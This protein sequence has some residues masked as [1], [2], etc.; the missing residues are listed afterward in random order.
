MGRVPNSTDDLE[1]AELALQRALLHGDVDALDQ[2]LDDELVSTLPG[3]RG[4]EG[5]AAVLEAHR[6]GILRVVRCD[7]EQQRVRVLTDL[8]LTFVTAG[9]AGSRGGVSFEARLRFTRNWRLSEAQ[10]GWQ[11]IAAH[12]SVVRTP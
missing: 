1:A 7:V 4:R 3:D 10:F 6:S 12:T 8:G 9:V 5:K 11:L 2:L